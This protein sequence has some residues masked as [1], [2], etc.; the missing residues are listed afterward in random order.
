MFCYGVSYMYKK[1]V[2]G[3]YDV[4]IDEAAAELYE[5]MPASLHGYWLL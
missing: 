4:S 1:F 2:M 5:M 3:A